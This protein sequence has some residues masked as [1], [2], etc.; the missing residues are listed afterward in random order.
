MNHPDGVNHREYD[1]RARRIK[2]LYLARQKEQ[3]TRNLIEWFTPSQYGTGTY[4]SG[5]GTITYNGGTHGNAR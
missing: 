3:S 4:T 1:Q 2:R 5:G